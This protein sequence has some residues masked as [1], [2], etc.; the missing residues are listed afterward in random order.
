MK[1]MKTMKTMT[2]TM[3]TSP[4]PRK[5][6]MGM[7]YLNKG[8]ANSSSSSSRP[9]GAAWGLAVAVAPVV[10]ALRMLFGRLTSCLPSIE[11]YGKQSSGLVRAG[12]SIRSGLSEKAKQ[13]CY[14]ASGK[15]TTCRLEPCTSLL[16]LAIG[17]STRSNKLWKREMLLCPAGAVPQAQQLKQRRHPHLT[18]SHGGTSTARA[19]PSHSATTQNASG[20]PVRSNLGSAF[21][22]RAAGWRRPSCQM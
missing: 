7:L 3:T 15:E 9:R 18:A 6:T 22:T 19:R 17:S 10:L 8:P 16:G 14:R 2:R 1:T 13:L 5:M 12:K 4:A 21:C 20:A 11:P